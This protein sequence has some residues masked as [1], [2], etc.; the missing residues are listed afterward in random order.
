MYAG[1]TDSNPNHRAHGCA[2]VEGIV[3]GV[4]GSASGKGSLRS[5]IRA[6]TNRRFD[7]VSD[8]GAAEGVDDFPAALAAC[9]IV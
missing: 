1:V 9:L 5:W 8:H 6:V 7:W 2:E 3:L 4:V